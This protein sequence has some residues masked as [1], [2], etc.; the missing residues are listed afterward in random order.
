LL[1]LNADPG[2]AAT[3]L[4]RAVRASKQAWEFRAQRSGRA[5]LRFVTWRRVELGHLDAHIV[6]FDVVVRDSAPTNQAGC[7]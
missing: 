3:S 6:D 4:L 2:G 7:G 1:R 5:A